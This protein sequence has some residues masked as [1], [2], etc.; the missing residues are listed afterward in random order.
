[1]VATIAVAVLPGSAAATA[2]V[3]DLGDKAGA[4]PGPGPGS[5]QAL[6]VVGTA[7]AGF[8]D[9]DR[10]LSSAVG[11]GPYV[12]LS[13]AGFADDRREPVLPGQYVTNEMSSF[14]AGLVASAL[15]VLG[16]QPRAPACPG[17]PEC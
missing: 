2:V 11:A 13:A 7:A 14:T 5:V 12:I 1:M 3:S 4:I 6:P 16:A 15:D 17:A 8:G 9:A 10:L